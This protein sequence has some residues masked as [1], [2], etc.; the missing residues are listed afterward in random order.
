MSSSCPSLG[1]GGPEGHFLAAALPY[2]LLRRQL[3]GAVDCEPRTEPAPPGPE[4]APAGEG[5]L[6]LQAGRDHSRGLALAALAT[7]A[8]AAAVRPLRKMQGSRVEDVLER[9]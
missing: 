3:L 4:P 9:P 5:R 8:E 7:R 1:S 2:G 6:G